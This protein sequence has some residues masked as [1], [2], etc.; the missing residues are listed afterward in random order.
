MPHTDFFKDNAKQTHHLNTT[1]F[2]EEWHLFTEQSF[3]RAIH[4]AS[5]KIAEVFL[6][7]HMQEILSH[8]DPQAVAN[9][10]VAESAN[11]I[12]NSVI[13]HG[14]DVSAAT[15][16]LASIMAK[17]RFSFFDKPIS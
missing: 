12:R 15:H 7:K 10:A 3:A 5:E 1:V 2:A 11:G 13:E 16:R 9:L 8:M 14:K 6:E 4:V 17:K